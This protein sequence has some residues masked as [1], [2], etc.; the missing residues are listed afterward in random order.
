VAGFAWNIAGLG[1]PGFADQTLALLGQTALPAGL[2]CVGAAMR[3][4]KGTGPVGAHLWWLAV[5]MA[6]LPAIA[7][8]LALWAGFGTLE[9][10]ILVL[11]AALPTATN[12][13]ILAVRMTGDGRA[14]A[15]QVTLGTV[16]SM[17]TLP[18]WMALAAA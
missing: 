18:A 6:A 11:V 16:L 12:A 10:S 3:L 4:E 7:W 8:G 5:K 9:R 15:T 14:V 2:L 1:L 13:Y 17:A